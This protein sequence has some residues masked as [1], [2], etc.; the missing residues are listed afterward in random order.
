MELYK[1]IVFEVL[2]VSISKILYLIF[3]YKNFHQI[4][5][6]IIIIIIYNTVKYLRTFYI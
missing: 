6:P 3:V 4:N 2:L 5:K 1:D